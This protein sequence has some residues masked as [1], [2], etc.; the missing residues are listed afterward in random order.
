MIK[1]IIIVFLNKYS[2]LFKFQLTGQHTN[3]IVSYDIIIINVYIE[4]LTIACF[5]KI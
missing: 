4:N 3:Y 2:A 1:Y 5:I